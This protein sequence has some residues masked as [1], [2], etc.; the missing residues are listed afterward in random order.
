MTKKQFQKYL[1]R[2]GGCVHCGDTQ[3]AVPNHRANRGM[4]GS[5]ERDVPS[6]VVVLCSAM[7][8]LIESDSSF[9]EV[10]RDNGWKLSTGQDP[11]TSPFFDFVAGRWFLADNFYNRVIFLDRAIKV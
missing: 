11:E 9:A 1:D 2:D 3:T 5:K 7:N 4:G 6:N 10:A 8:G